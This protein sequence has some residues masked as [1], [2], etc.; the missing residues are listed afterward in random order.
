VKAAQLVKV[1][2]TCDLGLGANGVLGVPKIAGVV[3]GIVN[4]IA[5]R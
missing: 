4:A 5:I 3:Q 1:A 2:K